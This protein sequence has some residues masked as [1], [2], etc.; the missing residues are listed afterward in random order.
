[1][2]RDAFEISIKEVIGNAGQ[3]LQP[4]VAQ[5]IHTSTTHHSGQL[6]FI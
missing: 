4:M 6:D 3:D 5:V 1:M 2:R